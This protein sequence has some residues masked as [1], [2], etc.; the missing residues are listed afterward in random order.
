MKMPMVA[1]CAVRR[2]D[3]IDA[4]DRLRI[5]DGQR[6]AP[7]ASS[8]EKLHRHLLEDGGQVRL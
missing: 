1:I 5:V 3:V 2:P 8:A 7:F 6:V 4:L